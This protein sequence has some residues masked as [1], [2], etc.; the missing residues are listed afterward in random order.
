MDDSN[1]IERHAIGIVFLANGS[2]IMIRNDEKLLKS[3]ETVVDNKDEQIQ[4]GFAYLGN[5]HKWL[6][7]SKY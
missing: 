1:I 3:G 6:S 4:M 7:E 2:T 5:S